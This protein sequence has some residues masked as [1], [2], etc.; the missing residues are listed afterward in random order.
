MLQ[1]PPQT[2]VLSPNPPLRLKLKRDFQDFAQGQLCVVVA[3]RLR[4]S[5]PV[6]LIIHRAE[7]V[8]SSRATYG[9]AGYWVV[10]PGELMGAQRSEAKAAAARKNG[11]RPKRKS[12]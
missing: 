9:A 5:G 1:L 6:K 10:G 11:C 3:G 7:A 12:T 4:G 8:A 2:L